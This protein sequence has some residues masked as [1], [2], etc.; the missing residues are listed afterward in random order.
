MN[1]HDEDE[2]PELTLEQRL[3]LTSN[4][5]Y[6]E[7]LAEMVTERLRKYGDADLEQAFLLSYVY[8]QLEE[9]VATE[10]SLANML[11]A[12]T[13]KLAQERV[14]NQTTD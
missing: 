14:A 9:G 10:I 6:A 13:V 1:E 4:E 3:F 7:L 5:V 8:G 2:K 12:M 11:A